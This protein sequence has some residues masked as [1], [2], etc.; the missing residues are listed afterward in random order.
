MN[1][2][3]CLSWHGIKP[4]RSEAKQPEIVGVELLKHI[5]NESDKR[6]RGF[7]NFNRTRGHL[8][9]CIC[10]TRV[11]ENSFFPSVQRLY[12]K[13][14]RTHTRAARRIIASAAAGFYFGRS[15]EIKAGHNC[16]R[17]KFNSS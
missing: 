8:R 14:T 6:V 16:A 4:R 17:A 15:R 2:R 9:H 10:I 11:V 3:Y 7:I 5:Q 12:I 13:L 1:V